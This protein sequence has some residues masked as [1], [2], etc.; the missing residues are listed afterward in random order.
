[1]SGKRTLSGSYDKSLKM[2]NTQTG[3]ELS[4]L[5]HTGWVDS[6]CFSP[7]GKRTLSGSWDKALERW[8]ADTSPGPKPPPGCSSA[9]PPRAYH[10]HRARSD[11]PT[12]CLTGAA[13]AHL[14]AFPA[15][16]R[17]SAATGGRP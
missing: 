1:M 5:I 14:T 8:D 2:W 6:V 7:D 12:S 16:P 11:A 9:G 15:L 4:T 10:P 3:R 17:A 13:L